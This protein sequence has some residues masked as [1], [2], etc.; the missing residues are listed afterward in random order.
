M[1]SHSF[2]E[3]GLNRLTAFEA[4]LAA[5]RTFHPRISF[6][7]CYEKHSENVKITPVLIGILT[8]SNFILTDRKTDCLMPTSVDDW[9]TQDHLARFVVEVIDGLDLSNLTC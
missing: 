6:L 4:K 7:D 1:C 5:C 3:G 2:T 9:L 8:M